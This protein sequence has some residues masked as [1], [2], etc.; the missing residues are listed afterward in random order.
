MDKTCPIIRTEMA[1]NSTFSEIAAFIR[2][3]GSEFK[4]SPWSKDNAL[5]HVW[6]YEFRD[7]VESIIN[8]DD[9]K[10][11][12][13]SGSSGKWAFV[14]YCA[15]LSSK[16]NKSI[17]G[18]SASIGFY[19]AY[20][21]SSDNRR[22][23]LTLMVATNSKNE[24]ALTRITSAISKKFPLRGFN[25]ET[26]SMKL[27]KDVHNYSAATAIFKEYDLDENQSDEAFTQ[28]LLTM[29]NHYMGTGDFIAEIL[30]DN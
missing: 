16:Y 27:G 1:S 13:G 15:V 12:C 23:Y 28:D 6:N 5:M 7:L 22:L 14:P 4:L 17:N 30:R 10:I 25:S 29:W 24:R 20:L 9:V 11:K 3:N 26:S 19:P 18:Y 21:L 2:N 8:Q